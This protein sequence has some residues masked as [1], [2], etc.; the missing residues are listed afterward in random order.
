MLSMSM[1]CRQVHCFKCTTNDSWC[2]ARHYDVYLIWCDGSPTTT[3][4][5]SHHHHHRWMCKDASYI[6]ATLFPMRHIAKTRTFIQIN[7][8]PVFTR[9]FLLPYYKYAILNLQ[10]ISNSNSIFYGNVKK[11]IR[12]WQIYLCASFVICNCCFHFRWT[13]Y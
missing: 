7:T 2:Q 4:T 13:L 10:S 8:L 3:T 9:L 6:F 1:S 11:P 5:T 12:I